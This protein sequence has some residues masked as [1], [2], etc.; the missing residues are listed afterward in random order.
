MNFTAQSSIAIVAARMAN[1][2]T[3]LSLS[4][5]VSMQIKFR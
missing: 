3:A 2:W 5:I 1:F 4:A